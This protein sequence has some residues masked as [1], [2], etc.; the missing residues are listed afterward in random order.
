MDFSTSYKREIM[1][2]FEIENFEISISILWKS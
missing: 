2:E 1:E